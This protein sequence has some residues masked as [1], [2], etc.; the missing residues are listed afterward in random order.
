MP[1]VVEER[2]PISKVLAQNPE[3][4]GLDTAKFVFTDISYGVRDRVS[5]SQ[6]N[7]VGICP[8]SKLFCLYVLSKLSL[9]IAQN[10]PPSKLLCPLQ[11]WHHNSENISILTYFFPP[12]FLTLREEL[13]HSPPEYATTQCFHYKS[14]YFQL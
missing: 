3:L 10:C 8:S 6:V 12:N 1:P 13:P 9:P 7:W 11:N 2:K 5:L 4:R 14:E